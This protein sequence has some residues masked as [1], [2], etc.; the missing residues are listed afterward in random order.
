MT[1]ATKNHTTPRAAGAARRAENGG[2][3]GMVTGSTRPASSHLAEPGRPD[4][5]FLGQHYGLSH[6]ITE[7]YFGGI[8]LV[9]YIISIK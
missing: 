8:W 2:S 9:Y 3:G 4:T 5:F 7:T 1:V 6:T